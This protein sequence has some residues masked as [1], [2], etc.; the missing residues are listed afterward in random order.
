MDNE[1]TV[2][3]IANNGTVAAPSYASTPTTL[4][5][6]NGGG[7]GADPESGLLADAKGD[8][9][10]TTELGGANGDGTGTVFEITN[11]GT[12][13]DP[14]YA[15]VATTLVSFNDSDGEEPF[16][17]LI[18]DANGD[19]FG[20]TKL[21]GANGYGT[22]FEIVNN[23]SIAAP[24]YASAPTTLVSF[25]GSNGAKPESGLTISAN[26]DLLGTTE[27]GGS[28]G[29]GTV[30]ELKNSASNSGYVAPT[31]ILSGA[32][33][34]TAF[35]G[36]AV[37]LGATDTTA[38][39]DQTLGDV[40][41]TG[42]PTNLSGFNGGSYTPPSGT[43]IGTAA[44]FNALSFDAGQTTG[45]FTLSI[46]ATTAGANAGAP[47]TESY[48]LIVVPVP[49][50]TV[51][52]SF[53]GGDGASP[54]AGLI[55]DANGD[56]FG[57]TSGGGADGDGAVFEIANSGSVAAPSYASAPS[58]VVNFDGKN[59]YLS[60]L[61]ADANGDMF[62]T[63]TYRQ[64]VISRAEG[65]VFEIANNGS[66]AAPSY[67]GAP[68]TLVSFTGL[69]SWG[70]LIADANG[71]LFGTTVGDGANGDGTVFEIVNNG[72]VA[73][74][75]YASAPTTLFSFNGSNG[76]YPQ[77]GL[78]ADAN[79]D[80][81]GT[82]TG[83]G[84]NGDGTVFEIV[85]NG[86][87]AAPNYASAPTTLVSFNG[88]NG[89]YPQAS[90]IVDAKGDLFGTT[91]SGGANG[92]GA[93]FEIVNNGSVAAPSYASAPITLVSFN[94]GDGQSPEASLI[95]DSNG[96]LFG[97]TY[98]G[99]ANGDGAVFEIANNGSV[100]APSYAD[101]P[102]TLV[103]FNGSNGANPE[104]GLIAGANG[105]LFGTTSSGGVNGDGAVFE[106]T[107]SGFIPFAPALAIT[108]ATLASNQTSLTLSGTIDAADAGAT[109]SIY[110]GSTLL[111]STAANAS[112]AWSATVTV[113]SQ[114]A[115]AL[116]ANATNAGGAGVSN[117][118]DDL[119]NA[120][121]AAS[122]G[123][124]IV[125]FSGAGD[126]ATLSNSSGDSDSVTGSNGTVYLTS[127]WAAVTGGGDGIVFAGGSGNL[128]SLY[129]TGGAWDTV[130]GSNGTVNLSSAQAAVTGGGDA[131]DFSGGSGN[132]VGLY[133]TGG[134]WDTVSGSNGTVYLT[135]AQA[136]VTGGGDWINFAGGTG[137]A[138]SLY[139]TGGS[140]DGVIGSNGTVYLESAQ[141]AVYGGGD[142]INF[143]GG[144]GNAAALYNTGGNWDGVIGASAL[145]YLDSAQAAVYG[146]GDWIYFAG[147]TGNAASLYSTGGSWDGVIGSNGTVY[148]ESAQTAVYGGGDWIDF[149]G[150][151]GNAASLYS[152]G[153]SWDG[154]IGSN[155][156]VYLESAQTA[157]YGGGDW[158]DFASG[159][160]NAASLYNTG[161]NWDGVIGSNGTVYLESAQTAVYGGGD[162]IDF[163]GGSGN[164]A[165]LYS[166]GGSWDGVIGSN[167]TVYLES[168]QATVY[169]TGDTLDLSG[170][171]A[172]TA[173]GGSDA[174]VFGVAIGT[175]VINGFASTD[176]IQFSK[177][178]FANWSAL[179]PDIKQ[180]GANTVIKL[181]AS[182]TVTLD[183]VTATTLTSSEFKFA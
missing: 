93:V 118:V 58:A 176:A 139:S 131:I 71:D 101:A 34:A 55:A 65:T 134:S 67:S 69:G 19:L 21:G 1:G 175:E 2:F 113:S 119:V 129:D 145:V 11:N 59:I 29:D 74:P 125:V 105:D 156:T 27:N 92:D 135:S 73:A 170:T 37:T 155:G 90:L 106:I 111:G 178:D 171:S 36:G 103:S 77:A 68:A 124:Q 109:I 50:L 173:N 80:L 41:I 158:I 45:A 30:F 35:E 46:S 164:A 20:T 95:V 14:S 162:W 102:T 112:G 123:G 96:D 166:T 4:V 33:S 64:S 159:T 39:S 79:G 183:G 177:S 127:A 89:D 62:G 115:H 121:R 138:A 48:T 114:G 66:V 172:V 122:G 53:N 104:A 117:F 165:A 49:T 128:A 132:A 130:T 75:N 140:W 32:D 86:S 24:N 5:S 81:F 141:T 9:F 28:D 148:L 25:N 72:S 52:A 150:G 7:D 18:A 42:L 40:T 76:G 51:L 137:N 88:S 180:S 100:A 169:G 133:S 44:Q 154:V 70:G 99:G 116:S 179:Q 54:T 15:S 142:W 85:N 61:T 98:G 87:F 94:G 43:W 182:N 26:G 91:S 151:T 144:T 181:N 108:A 63:I 168:A 60:G 31:P 147:G 17:G 136:A 23:G 107:D 157:V 149:A 6:L 38:Y 56:L 110:D 84:A 163:A 12:V 97:T 160:G 153:G 13:A 47:A 143:A 8:L 174:F 167:G 3:E 120:Q 152:T 78:V 57:T 83:G 82:T 161:G 126:S 10:G 16:A 22:V 146:G